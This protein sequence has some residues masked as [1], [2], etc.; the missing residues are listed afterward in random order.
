MEIQVRGISNIGEILSP[1]IY[2]KAMM[3]AINEVS[4]QAFTKVKKE[5][6]STYTL[7]SGEVK[8]AFSLQKAYMTKLTCRLIAKGIAGLPVILFNTK[9]SK[10]KKNYGKNVKTQI[11]KGG[12]FHSWRSGFVEEMASGH[13][14]VFWRAPEAMHK[15]IGTRPGKRGAVKIWSGALPIKQILSVSPVQLMDNEH[16]SDIING[17]ID[18]DFQTIFNRNYDYLTSSIFGAAR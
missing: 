10:G 12:K 7:P 16:I 17:L 15:V 11:K 1:N 18:K 5:I 14:G 6:T 13:R 8:K 9:Y 3:R 2:K 4:Q